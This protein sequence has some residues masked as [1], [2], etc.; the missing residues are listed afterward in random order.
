MQE[1]NIDP[2]CFLDGWILSMM[3]KT[4]PLK[5]MHNVLILFRKV[6]WSFMYQLIV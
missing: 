2:R 5:Y 3:S 6:G 4:I 1:L